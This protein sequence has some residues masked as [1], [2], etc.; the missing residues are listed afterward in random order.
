MMPRA[1]AWMV[2]LALGVSCAPRAPGEPSPVEAVTP[3]VRA[4]CILLRAFV[5]DGTLHEVCAT[6]DELAPLVEEIIAEREQRAVPP[7][8]AVRV[9]FAVPAPQR[10]IP[11]RRCVQWQHV[12][13]DAGAAEVDG[14][15]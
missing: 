9:A 2:L 15:Q 8:A 11:R 7:P 1:R 5:A 3:A 12:G 14:G 6:A 13:A 10:A 4:T